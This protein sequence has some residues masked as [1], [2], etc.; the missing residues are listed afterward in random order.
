MPLVAI[1]E[2]WAV[3]LPKKTASQSLVMACEATGIACV[4]GEWHGAEWEGSGRR[5]MLVRDPRERLASMYWWALAGQHWDWG[6]GSSSDWFARFLE[7][8]RSPKAGDLEWITSQREMAIRFRPDRV[9]HL[10][11]GLSLVLAAIG[12]DATHERWV[13]RTLERKRA[14]RLPFAETFASDIPG[15]REWLIEDAG[16]WY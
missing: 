9:F 7:K 15:M 13:N 3:C 1:D 11:D 5:F 6:P 8:R 14:L 10:E 2:S 4:V 12:L 16:E